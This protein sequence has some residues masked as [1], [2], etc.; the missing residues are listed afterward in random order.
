VPTVPLDAARTA[1]WTY[2][3]LADARAAHATCRDVTLDVDRLAQV[4]D[5]MQFETFPPIEPDAPAPGDG[6]PTREAQIDFTLVTGAI[7]FAY[8]DFDTRVPWSI[9]VD[10]REL[11]DADAMF[12]RFEQAIAAGIPVLEGTWLAEVTPA[13]LGEI[14]HGPRPI[15]MLAERAAVLR[16]VGRVLVDRYAGRFHVFVEDCPPRLYADGAGMLERLTREFSAYD[17][18]S[19]LHGR[20]VR[21]DKLAQ[22]GMWMLHH[23]GLV[24]FDDIDALSAF[25]DYIVPAA[26]RAMGVLR[27]SPPLAEAVDEG[28]LLPA[29]STWENEIRVQTV[30]ACGLLTDALN[31][32][33]PG[34]PLI[35]PQIDF[36]LWSAFHDRI[37]PHHLTQT[38]AY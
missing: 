38:T 1:A 13:A 4:A 19:V 10:G 37:R 30:Y 17:D 8:T 21:I 34:T 11:I 15:P 9:E 6:G 14:L 20:A 25:A 7:N 27:Y 24:R 5:W 12:V 35:V 33:R 29:G 32:R 31:A 2:P 28:V 36:R 23:R 22:L 3:V 26:L 16:S 18:S